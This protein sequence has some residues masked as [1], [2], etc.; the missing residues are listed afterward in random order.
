MY[1]LN[2]CATVIV[3][4]FEVRAVPTGCLIITGEI[5]R[6]DSTHLNTENRWFSVRWILCS[7][8]TSASLLIVCLFRFRFSFSNC[9]ATGMTTGTRFFFIYEAVSGLIRNGTLVDLYHRE[10]KED[11]ISAIYSR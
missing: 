6:V 10:E 9:R 4:F 11:E 2:N 8:L 3:E 5:S 7:Q 1:K